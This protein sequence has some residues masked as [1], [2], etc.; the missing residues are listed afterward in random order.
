MFLYSNEHE[1]L[2]VSGFKLINEGN[3][4][5]IY[6]NGE[7]ALKI[8]R[9]DCKYGNIMSKGMFEL[10]KLLNIPGLVKLHKY[11]NNYNGLFS[12]IFPMDAYSMDF[13]QDEHTDITNCDREFLVFCLKKLEETLICL[14]DN[15]VFL[16]DVHCHNII[17]ND[18]GVT[19][20]DPDKFWHSKNAS[21]GN[22]YEH[23]KREMLY[24][25]NHIIHRMCNEFNLDVISIDDIEGKP[26][27][28]IVLAFLTE[29]TIYE[30]VLSKQKKYH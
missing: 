21:W 11:Y 22:V 20:V 29:E 12:R 15:N 7:I 1:P 19:I 10:L 27:S 28:M 5:L 13:I 26:F 9:F 16:H 17:I 2:D 24:C 4:A 6:T 23:N 3:C 8:Y 30:T 25:L 18:N 14:S